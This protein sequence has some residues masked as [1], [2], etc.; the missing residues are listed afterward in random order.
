MGKGVITHIFEP[1]EMP[2]TKN[3]LRA[4]VI[5]DPAATVN[6][7]NFARKYEQYLNSVKYDLEL[8]LKRMLGILPQDDAFIIK[9]KIN[10]ANKDIL[11]TVLERLNRYHDIVSPKQGNWMRGLPIEKKIGYLVSSLTGYIIDYHPANT[12]REL[13]DMVKMLNEEF[14]STYDVVTYKDKEG[15]IHTTKEKIR[16]GS[17]YMMLLE[18]IGYDWSSVST[19]KTQQNGIISYTSTK[20]KHA[21]PTKQQPTRVLGESEI[22]VIAAYAGGEFAI[23]MHDRSNNSQVRKEIVN[24]ILNADIPTKIDRIVDRE[25]IPLGY[26]KPLQLVNHLLNCAGLEFKYKKFDPSQ[27]VPVLDDIFIHSNDTTTER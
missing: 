1:H 14:P 15:N 4:D 26:S 27:Q 5:M 12:E 2:V 9:D 6:R 8:D 3:G 19:A 20:D 10:S 16:I 22:R 13:L 24:S 25:K 11:N 17:I 18:K 7:M 21:T 23:E